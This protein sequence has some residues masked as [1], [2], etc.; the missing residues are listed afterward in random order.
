MYAGKKE[1]TLTPARLALSASPATVCIQLIFALCLSQFVAFVPQ[2]EKRLPVFNGLETVQFIAMAGSQGE[3]QR[4]R[5]CVCSSSASA[6]E[7]TVNTLLFSSQVPSSVAVSA[8]QVTE[9]AT[10]LSNCDAFLLV[11][12]GNQSR[13]L[14][15]NSARDTA[16]SH[17]ALE[18]M[19]KLRDRGLLRGVGVVLAVAGGRVRGFRDP[20]GG[21]MWSPTVENVLRETDQTLAL[22]LVDGGS[23]VSWLRQLSDAQ[24]TFLMKKLDLRPSAGVGLPSTQVALAVAGIGLAVTAGVLHVRS[25]SNAEASGKGRWQVYVLVGAGIALIGLSVGR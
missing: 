20:E 12:D 9:S 3:S 6:L 14:V 5:L 2:F 16:P 17:E 15:S 24:V 4:C 18:E 19:L 22:K 23:A 21:S 8:R 7:S 1:N 13:L 11:A 10:D 25:S